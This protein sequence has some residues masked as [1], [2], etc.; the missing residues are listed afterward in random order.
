MTC[1]DAQVL[2]H[3]EQGFGVGHVG[4]HT[5]V[6]ADGHFRQQRDFRNSLRAAA[7]STTITV[8][9]NATT[10]YRENFFIYLCLRKC[11]EPT[12]APTFMLTAAPMVSNQPR[13]AAIP[14]VSNP[15]SAVVEQPGC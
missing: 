4:Q 9:S 6:H 8:A 1:V 2:P 12:G 13:L 5:V 3:G 14:T 10:R 15:R 7:V 11:N